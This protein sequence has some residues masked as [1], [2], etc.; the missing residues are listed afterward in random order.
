MC[1]LLMCFFPLLVLVQA[2]KDQK[3]KKKEVLL[4]QGTRPGPECLYCCQLHHKHAVLALQW[5][6]AQKT[7]KAKKIQVEIEILKSCIAMRTDNFI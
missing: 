5:I 4:M 7:D 3:K 1:R 2:P 6:L